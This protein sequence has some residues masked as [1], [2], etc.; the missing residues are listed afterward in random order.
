[1]K[2]T[3]NQNAKAAFWF[4]LAGLVVIGA[5]GLWGLC[6]LYKKMMQTILTFAS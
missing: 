4:F 5:T 1:M 2:Q 3:K 6:W